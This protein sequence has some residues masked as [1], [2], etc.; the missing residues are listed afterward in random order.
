MGNQKLQE[1]NIAVQW[2]VPNRVLYMVARGPL[3]EKDST[4][5]DERVACYL[6]QTTEH[7]HILID[8]T[9]VQKV[10]TELFH[11]PQTVMRHPHINW[12]VTVGASQ[13]PIINFG[14]SA[15]SVKSKIRYRDWPH[16]QA[17]L[18]VLQRMDSTLPDLTDYHHRLV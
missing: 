3:S 16:M 6:S 5:A 4:L 7:M 18:D 2:Y 11:M 9:R 10:S 15:L 12:I 13:N 14:I 17:A 1:T 8:I